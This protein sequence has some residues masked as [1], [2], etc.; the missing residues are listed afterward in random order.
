MAYNNSIPQPGDRLKDSQ[1]QVLANF[2]AIQALIDV[3]HSIFGDAEEGKHKWIT[4]PVQPAAPAL[5]GDNGF[6][7]KLYA[8]TAK[9]ETYIHGQKSAGTTDIPFTASILSNSVQISDSTG[10]TYLPSGILLRWENVSGFNGTTTV[11]LGG[12]FPA[13]TTIYSVIA[14]PYNLTEPSTTFAVRLVDILSNT[15]FRLKSTG[16][17]GA[18]V[19][20][21]GV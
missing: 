5:A 11:T 12:G 3:N 15:Q 8:A 14:T 1:P 16:L 7:N 6:Y 19:L 21:I 9:N 10:W 13:F 17:T 20:I 18:K 2:A 4:L